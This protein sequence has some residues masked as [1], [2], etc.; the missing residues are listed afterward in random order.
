MTTSL[1]CGGGR[2]QRPPAVIAFLR[3]ALRSH[4][5]D[6]AASESQNL[7]LICFLFLVGSRV[8]SRLVVLGLSVWRVKG[9]AMWARND[10]EEGF[11]A[12]KT[13]SSTSSPG[14]VPGCDSSWQASSTATSITN[15]GRRHSATSDSGDTGIGTS[16]SDSVE[17]SSYVM[18][19]VGR[20]HLAVEGS[21][22]LVGNVSRLDYRPRINIEVPNDLL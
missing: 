11:D 5:R 20:C 7:P 8:L 12:Y 4:P 15:R 22:L 21:V 1:I 10:F 2:S 3:G 14:W 6:A 16:C 19:C 13:G 9:T 17:G 18:L